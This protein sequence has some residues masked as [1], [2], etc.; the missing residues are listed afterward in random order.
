MDLGE[1]IS[2][3][4][5]A[6]LRR[7][8]ASVSD[9]NDTVLVG[10]SGSGSST[11]AHLV[12]SAL[13]EK[14]IPVVTMDYRDVTPWQEA[15]RQ[16]C[17]TANKIK[18]ETGRCAALVIDHCGD[19]EASEVRDVYQEVTTAASSKFH[20]RLWVG[21]LDCRSREVEDYLPLIRNPKALVLMPEYQRDDLLQIYSIIGRKQ[22]CEW[23]EAILYFLHDWCGSDLTLV[24]GVSTFLYGEWRDRLYDESVAE[25]LDRWLFADPVVDE[26]RSTLRRMGETAWDYVHLLCSGGKVPCHAPVIEH[27]T[28]SALRGLFFSGFV[29]P[30][31]IPGFYQFRNLTVKLLAM[32]EH[33]GTEITSASLLRRS[34]NARITGLLQDT[35]LSLRHLLTRCFRQMGFDAVKQKL[36]TTKT[37]ES[38]MP[39]ELRKSLSIWAKQTGGED[40]QQKLMKHLIEYTK[41]FHRT[42]NLWAHVCGHHSSE[43]GGNDGATQEPTVEMIVEYLTFNELSNLIQSLCPKIFPN[44]S[45]EMPGRQPPAKS[46]PAHLARL[47]RLRNQSAHLRNVTF[48]DMEDLLTA[49]RE[50]RRDIK[51]HI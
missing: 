12:S 21:S 41:D 33:M 44:W 1:V 19:M 30:N 14:E 3:A 23:G 2:P 32:R 11:L 13:G 28:D 18:N 7:L 51:D 6:M 37:D 43:I 45:K 15:Y 10:P 22:G 39:P 24:E 16:S 29:T 47:S 31:L 25:C 50:M 49:T 38:P 9:G 35:E 5:S 46:W 8:V 36:K 27:E 4:V 48:Q 34:S 26:R 42:H 40:L 17:Q 20:A